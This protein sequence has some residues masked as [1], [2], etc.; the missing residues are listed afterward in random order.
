MQ[1]AG[2]SVNVLCCSGGHAFNLVGEDEFVC[3]VLICVA[4]AGRPLWSPAVLCCE[5]AAFVLFNHKEL[6]HL[7]MCFL[8]I[9]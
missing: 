4:G 9:Q 7:L 8:N 6:L 3:N 1:A 2:W 5:A